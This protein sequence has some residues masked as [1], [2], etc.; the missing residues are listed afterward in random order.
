MLFKV[1][2]NDKVKVLVERD[3]AIKFAELNFDEEDDKTRNSVAELLIEIYEQTGINFMNSKIVLEVVRGISQSYYIIVT[4]II[5]A[6]D[7]TDSITEDDEVDMYIFRLAGPET[8]FDII[9]VFKKSN[10]VFPAK[11]EL[12]RYKKALYICIGFS[13]DTMKNESFTCL[14]D[15]LSSV[16][17]R[18]KWNIVNDA[19]LKEWGTLISSDIFKK[20]QA[21]T[22]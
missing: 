2:N 22:D 13:V 12:Y 17:E 3:D 9:D 5:N 18:C 1:I 20:I 10:T 19:I 11:S 21:A 8:L 14:I 4:R 15:E 6:E 16:G 7:K